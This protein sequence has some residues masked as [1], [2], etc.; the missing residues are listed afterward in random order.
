MDLRE[1]T[2]WGGARR[3]RRRGNCGRGA[4]YDKSVFSMKIFF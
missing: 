2:D 3:D 4:W 1:R